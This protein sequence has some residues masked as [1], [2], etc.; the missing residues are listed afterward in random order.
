LVQDGIYDRFAELLV[1]SVKQLKLGHGLEKET[2]MGPLT[3]PQSMDRLDNQISDSV[4]YGAKILLGGKRVNGIPGYFYEPTVLGDMSSEM[5]VNR[6]ETF[7]PICSLFRFKTEEEVVKQANDTNVCAT[8]FRRW[9]RK[10]L[11]SRLWIH[12][13]DWPVI[14]SRRMS[15]APSE[16]SRTSRR[17]QFP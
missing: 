7:G 14:S 2:T 10:K 17:A 16:C 9:A 4:K 11:T 3:T 12:R 5:L 1:D 8:V 6:E 15:T 13:W